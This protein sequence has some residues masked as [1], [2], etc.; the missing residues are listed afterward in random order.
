MTNR[1]IAAI[2]GLLLAGTVV[3]CDSAEPQVA[4]DIVGPASGGGRS[5]NLT[6]TVLLASEV[7]SGSPRYP[8]RVVRLTDG[9]YVA[10]PTFQPG[11]VALYS[12]GGE[13]EAALGEFGEG[14]GELEEVH[15]PLR[16][17]GDSLAVL[18][19]LNSVTVFDRAGAAARSITLGSTS[20][21][22]RRVHTTSSGTVLAR[23]TGTS[24][25]TDVPLREFSASGQ[26]IREFGSEAQLGVGRTYGAVASDGGTV[27][28]LDTRRYEIDVFAADAA[29]DT[30]ARQLDWFPPDGP[31]NEW[32][33]RPSISDAVVRAP[34]QLVVLIQRPRADY[35]V[36]EAP[37]SGGP[38]RAAG[39]RTD[40][41]DLMERY[42]QFIEILDLERRE[43]IASTRVED[44][45]IGGFVDGNEAFTYYLDLDSG[46]A[47]VQLWRISVAGEPQQ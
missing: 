1:L 35:E 8:A 32:G 34:G 14:P 40:H 17:A 30:I 20:F 11:A 27:Y 7:G 23:R 25:G 36:P 24:G 38:A 12:S 6:P 21:L 47:G 28:A 33:G 2:A 3:G 44:E 4:D 43:V 39:R 10:G 46:I 15:E 19:D 41:R 13:F 31:R 16:W 45:W 42:E 22:T 18:H 5:V 26:T 29:P 9:S 37:S